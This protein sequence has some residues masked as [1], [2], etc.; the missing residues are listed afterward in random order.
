MIPLGTEKIYLCGIIEGKGL[1][2]GVWHLY[3][4]QQMVNSHYMEH[5]PGTFFEQI[6][7]GNELPVGSYRIDFFSKKQ[8]RAEVEF[9]VT[10]EPL[11][12]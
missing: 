12:N 10:S 5:F 3:K 2:S 4:E 9:T 11:S 7:L 8:V 6:S 1:L